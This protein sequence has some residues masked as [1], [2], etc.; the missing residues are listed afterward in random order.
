VPIDGEQCSVDGGVGIVAVV[1][2]VV[3]VVVSIVVISVVVITVVISVVFTAYIRQTPLWR[4]AELAQRQ[5]N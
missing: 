2:I 4:S 3:V 5:M 1:V